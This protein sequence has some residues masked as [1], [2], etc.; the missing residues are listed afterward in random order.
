MPNLRLVSPADAIEP[1]TPV[2]E[3][4]VQLYLRGRRPFEIAKQIGCTKEGVMYTLN[5]RLPRFDV[6]S[7]ALINRAQLEMMLQMQRVFYEQAVDHADVPSG[8]AALKIGERI[9]ASIGSDAGGSN[10]ACQ[11]ESTPRQNSTE[12]LRAAIERIVSERPAP[13]IRPGV[14]EAEQPH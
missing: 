8:M 14:D 5:D 3:Q 10:A 2:V 11:I 9:A 1:D 7:A 4:I 6:H 12:K 13:V